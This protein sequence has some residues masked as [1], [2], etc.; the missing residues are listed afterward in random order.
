MK[1][2]KVTVHMVLAIASELDASD[3]DKAAIGHRPVLDL[4]V[5]SDGTRLDWSNADHPVKVT[6][7]YTE[8]KA[9]A[10]RNRVVVW[11]I[12][13][14]GARAAVPNGRYDAAKGEVVFT[15][16]HFSHYAIASFHAT[17]SDIA[18]LPWAVDAI[19]G[20]GASGVVE[21]TGRKQFSPGAEVKRADFAV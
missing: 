3:A 19:E 21:G 14:D 4:F 11:Y 20:L 1:G 12:G 8:S 18:G 17:F 13:E 2:D 5:T 15:T 7:P 16:T 6:I 10:S 9:E